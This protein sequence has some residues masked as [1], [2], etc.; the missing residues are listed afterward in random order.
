MYFDELSNEEWEL[1]EPMLSDKPTT[2]L[3]RRGR[4]RANPRFV[5]NAILWILTTGE[6]WSSLPGRYPSGPTCRCRFE[7]W[8]SNGTLAKITRL[9]TQMG[10]TFACLPSAS[11]AVTR[12]ALRRDGRG[13]CDDGLRSVLWKSPESWQAPS[14][15]IDERHL[16]DPFDEI[17]RQLSG[18]AAGT[19][20]RTQSS[21][22]MAASSPRQLDRWCGSPWTATQ[23][24]S[25]DGYVIRASADPV[26]NQLF[27]ARAEIMRH[28]RRIERSGLIGP[29]FEDFEAARKYALDWAHKWIDQQ[30]TGQI[31]SQTVSAIDVAK[32]PTV[33]RL[34]DP[35]MEEVYDE[36]EYE[37]DS[38]GSSLNA[39]M[40]K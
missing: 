7:D 34:P 20:I 25:H 6:P 4:P 37:D 31:V 14:H 22:M 29:R 30:S 11:S 9:L 38:F 39:A 3:S 27:R 40:V 23:V 1:I 21:A 2:R 13:Q 17:T 15:K 10:R 19:P 12:P 5:A 33:R 18:R 8:Q 16:I 26:S 32:R 24:A 35:V 28:G 36:T